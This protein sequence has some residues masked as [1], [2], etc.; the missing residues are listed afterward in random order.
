MPCCTVQDVLS[1][2]CT[3]REPPTLGG[4]G[5][6]T[7]EAG[8]KGRIPTAAERDEMRTCG[9]K[10]AA[11]LALANDIQCQVRPRLRRWHHESEITKA[12]DLA[13]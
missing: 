8:A 1:G 2:T 10:S 12:W 3:P 4:D 11:G 7:S 9:F 13:P 5:M 6:P